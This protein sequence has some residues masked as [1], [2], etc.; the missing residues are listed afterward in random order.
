VLEAFETFVAYWLSPDR[1]PF[2][3]IALIFTVIGRFTSTKV[4]TRQRAYFKW[5]KTWQRHLWFWGRESLMVHPIAA[6]IVT[7][8]LL[9]PDP[10]GLGWPPVQSAGYFGAA[11]VVS[12]FLWAF[13]GA[14][15][16][17]RGVK[18]TL[19]GESVPPTDGK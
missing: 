8:L 19:P 16:K 11:G 14:I 10:E 1:W 5:P 2:W 15:A 9:W 4:F 12:M 7:G 18:L 17:A 3:S 13:I 6:G